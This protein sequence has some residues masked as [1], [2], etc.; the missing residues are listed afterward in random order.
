VYVKVVEPTPTKAGLKFPP[1]VTPF[2]LQVPPAGVAVRLIDG[3]FKQ[4]AK[5]VPAF[6]V[7]S[8]LTVTVNV[9]RE[10]HVPDPMLYTKL[11]FPATVGSK[12]PPLV[13]PNPVQVPPAGF[14]VKLT[15]GALIQTLESNPALAFEGFPTCATSVSVLVHPL[16]FVYV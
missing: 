8:G 12:I 16:A 2:P 5:S 7:G 1:V 13:I 6:T 11:K 10:T 3:A 9:S 4:M 14:P 15:L